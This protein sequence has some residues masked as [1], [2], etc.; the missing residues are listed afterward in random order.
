MMLQFARPCQPVL[1][2][3]TLKA[4][5]EHWSDVSIPVV[6]TALGLGLLVV[7]VGG[8]GSY[9]WHKKHASGPKPLAVFRE[10]ARLGGLSLVD[11]WLLFRIA[12]HQALPGPATLL[13]SP[14]TLRVHAVR[15]IRQA[16]IWR[17]SQQ[18]HRVAAIRRRLMQGRAAQSA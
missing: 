7:V 3:V 5:S 1:G 11:Q 10:L 8:V 2:E 13:F 18:L 14:R 12:R 17:R 16:V 9:R 15:Y 4:I 6:W